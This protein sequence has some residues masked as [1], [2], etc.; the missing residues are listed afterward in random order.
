[1]GYVAPV[2]VVRTGN[3]A[4]VKSIED[5][6][7]P[8]L[9]VALPNPDFSTCGEMLF[10]LLEKKGI[11]AAVEEN[12][13]GAIFRSHAETGNAI[14][15]GERDAGVMWNGTAHTFKDSLE[16]VPTEYEYDETI[17]VWVMGLSYT[18]KKALVEQ[19]LEFVK[20]EGAPIFTEYGYT[21]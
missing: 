10:A 15:I 18:Q 2:V 17:R 13:G 5:L 14:N 3:P 7:R 6:A 16:V 11:R 12:A 19:F 4:E 21:K 20:T 1:V 8:G 9:K